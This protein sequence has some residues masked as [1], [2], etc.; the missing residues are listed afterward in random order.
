M[1]MEE[2]DDACSP[3]SKLPFRE[4]NKIHSVDSSAEGSSQVQV[5]FVILSSCTWTKIGVPA[6]PA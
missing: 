4:E 6:F 2:P 5:G 1:A 3:F